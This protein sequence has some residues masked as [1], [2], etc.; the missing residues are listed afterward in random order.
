MP[1]GAGDTGVG[2]GSRLRTTVSEEDASRA[3]WHTPVAWH[4]RGRR[5]SRSS[6]SPLS[7]IKILSLA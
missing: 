2:Q 3:W 6:K 1:T 5:R 7:Y 4:V